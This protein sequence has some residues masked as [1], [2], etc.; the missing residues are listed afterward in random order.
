MQKR[1]KTLFNFLA[2]TKANGRFEFPDHSVRYFKDGQLHRDDGPALEYANGDKA[3]Y[4]DG[5]LHRDDGPAVE[6]PNGDREWYRDNQLHRDDGPA[7]ERIDGYKAWFRHGLPIASMPSPL[8]PA[9][10]L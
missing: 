9:P 8:P 2:K 6:L 4:R 7:I 5:Q 3:W 10:K 1:I